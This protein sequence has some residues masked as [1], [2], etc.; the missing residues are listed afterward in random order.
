[1]AQ[2]KEQMER[3]LKEEERER[4]RKEKETQDFKVTELDRLK[5]HLITKREKY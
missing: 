5:T 2:A 3:N 1:M 4:L